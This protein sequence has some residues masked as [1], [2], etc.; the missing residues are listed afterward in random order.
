MIIF[1]AV[2]FGSSPSDLRFQDEV[3]GDLIRM[4]D[5]VIRAL[6]KY[7]VRPI[8]YEGLLRVEPLEIPEGAL[9][10]A[11][12]NAIIHK[13]YT[14]AHIQMK[15]WDDRVELWNEGPL[16]MGWTVENLQQ[17]HSSKPR[18]PNLAKIFYMAGFIEHWGRG[19]D[20]IVKQ[21]TDADL[22]APQFKD[23][24]N[25][26]QVTF[27]RNVALRGDVESKKFDSDITRDVSADRKG[28]M[29]TENADRKELPANLAVH[30]NVQENVHVNVQEMSNK[31]L[32]LIA[33]DGSI[34]QSALA[35]I[36]N[37]TPKTIYRKLAKLQSLG[38]IRRV[39]PD[40][41]GHWEIVD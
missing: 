41:G 13:D 27:R 29:P 36:L 17:P 19:I 39:G 7:L 33:E 31:I 30:V 3:N 20:K 18:N 2:R 16:P 40:K 14:G 28:Q 37:V 24:L 10:E 9:R 11:I 6:D 34:T 21:T 25:G 8:H 15:V 38:R 26:L 35:K 4:P 5:K 12:Y 23:F 1:S 22:K 32:M